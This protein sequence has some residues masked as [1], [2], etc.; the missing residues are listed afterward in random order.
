MPAEVA[1]S[2]LHTLDGSFRSYTDRC[3]SVCVAVGTSSFF[4]SSLD[5]MR[6]VSCPLGAWEINGNNVG[7]Y[8]TSVVGIVARIHGFVQEWTR[9]VEAQSSTPIL[10]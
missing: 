10:E 8:E 9:F 5:N 7:F 2:S 3:F 4:S 6:R 1:W